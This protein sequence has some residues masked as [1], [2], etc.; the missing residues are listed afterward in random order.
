MHFDKQELK[1]DAYGIVKGATTSST[2]LKI[3]S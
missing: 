2:S 1:I 3:R